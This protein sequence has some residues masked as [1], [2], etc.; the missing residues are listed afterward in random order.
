MTVDFRL[1][2]SWNICLFDETIISSSWKEVT[3][4]LQKNMKI[5]FK[6]ILTKIQ[7]HYE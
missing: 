5:T 4:K 3:R 6:A 7:E 2:T 1:L